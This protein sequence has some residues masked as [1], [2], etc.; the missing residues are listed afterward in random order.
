MTEF[1]Q[2]LIFGS[3]LAMAYFLGATSSRKSSVKSG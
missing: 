2:I 3:S 1:M